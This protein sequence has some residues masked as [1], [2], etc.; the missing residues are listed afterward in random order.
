MSR[1]F[2]TSCLGLLAVLIFGVVAILSVLAVVFQQ[3][4]AV[5]SN[6]IATTRAN[7][8]P[9]RPPTLLMTPLSSGDDL[10]IQIQTI[11]P[12]ASSFPTDTVVPTNTISESSTSASPNSPE[13]MPTDMPR[14]LGTS[15]YPLTVTAEVMMGLTHVASYEAG[16]SATRTAVA[17]ESADIYATLTAAAPSPTGSAQ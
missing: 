17:A 2:R 12:I 11:T 8:T 1:I 14:Y 10:T 4:Q 13:M 5:R 9:Y 7:V 15:S 3:S 16:V 6:A